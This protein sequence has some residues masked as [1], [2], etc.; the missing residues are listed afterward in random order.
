MTDEQRQRVRH[1]ILLLAENM[2]TERARLLCCRAFHEQD[3]VDRGNHL[4]AWDWPRL[5]G[6]SRTSTSCGTDAH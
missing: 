5:E 2:L 6:W 4:P 3:R 1:R